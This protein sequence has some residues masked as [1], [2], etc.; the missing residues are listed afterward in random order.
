MNWIM[1]S[2]AAV[3]TARR[4]QCGVVN[5]CMFSENCPCILKK[6][7]K[8]RYSALFLISMWWNPFSSRIHFMG[9]T[10]QDHNPVHFIS[11]GGWMWLLVSAGWHH[12]PYFK[13]NSILHE[14]LFFF[15][16]LVPKELWALRYPDLSSPNFYFW[17][18]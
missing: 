7:K 9:H 16:H 3:W 2:L 11:G 15:D 12:V 6:K 5:I 4:V 17:A 14:S 18:T 1:F 8:T 10:L 13:Q